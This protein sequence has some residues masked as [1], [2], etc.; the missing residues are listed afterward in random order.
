[1]AKLIQA[2]SA[3][4]PKIKLGRRASMNEVVSLIAG[5][6]G[7]NKGDISQMISEL[8]EAIIFFA[9]AGRG[10]K[11][12]G[13]GTYTPTTNLEGTISISS[14]LDNEIK[15]EMNKTKAFEGEILNRDMI[16]KTSADLVTRWNEEHPEDPVS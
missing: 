6:T 10:V 11:I 2:V 9:L 16:G 13:L 12:D 15:S 14:R 1:M 3:Y 7:L 8:K 4:A 5:R